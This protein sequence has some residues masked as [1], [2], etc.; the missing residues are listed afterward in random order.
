[1]R[2]RDIGNSCKKEFFR[3]LKSRHSKARITELAAPHGAQTSD[4]EE[5]IQL[6]HDFYKDLFS[7]P[8]PSHA[9]DPQTLD[10][11]ERIPKIVTPEMNH[12]KQKSPWAGRGL[13]N[14]IFQEVLEVSWSRLSCHDQAKLGGWDAPDLCIMRTHHLTT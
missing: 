1:V 7:E 6:C 8:A 5:V 11:L 9:V 13:N 4:P 10:I 2:W 3:A 12:G 14:R